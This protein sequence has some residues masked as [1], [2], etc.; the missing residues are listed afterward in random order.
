MGGYPHVII[1]SLDVDK[2]IALLEAG[3]LGELADYLTSGV[4]LLV[5]AGADLRR[6]A[7]PEVCKTGRPNH[8][9]ATLSELV[10]RRAVDHFMTGQQSAGDHAACETDSRT[11]PSECASTG[12]LNT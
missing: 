3:R 5:R 7:R 11:D 1:N 9:L 12:W 2:G 4:E 6:G 8:R 10:R